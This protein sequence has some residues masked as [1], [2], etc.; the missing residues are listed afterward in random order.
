MCVYS[1]RSPPYLSWDLALGRLGVRDAG[2]RV[3]LGDYVTSPLVF[4]GVRNGWMALPA[5]ANSLEI[6]SL[7]KFVSL[8]GPARPLK[9]GVSWYVTIGEYSTRSEMFLQNWYGF[10][11]RKHAIANVHIRCSHVHIPHPAHCSV[12]ERNEASERYEKRQ[13]LYTDGPEPI[14]ASIDTAERR[15]SGTGR[16]T[17]RGTACRRR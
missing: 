4:R 16:Q 5:K 17:S 6:S 14:P 9:T 7:R 2:E 8:R 15:N 1:N 11:S 13:P 12:F 3:S 10:Q